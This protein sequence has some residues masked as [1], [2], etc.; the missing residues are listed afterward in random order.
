MGSALGLVA[1]TQGG[2]GA[3]AS[4]KTERSARSRPGSIGFGD[5]KATDEFRDQAH[6]RRS[7]GST[8]RKISPCFLSSGAMTLA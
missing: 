2:P 6:L 7:S 3:A 1:A 4:L 5:R 8:S